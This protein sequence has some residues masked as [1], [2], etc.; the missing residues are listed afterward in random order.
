MRRRFSGLA[1][2]GLLLGMAGAGCGWEDTAGSGGIAGPGERPPARLL[3]QG[4][5]WV[6]GGTAWREVT[7][8]V[9]PDGES[10]GSIP[11]YDLGDVG[12]SV[13][14]EGF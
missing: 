9:P 6:D 11:L 4:F 7:I 3:L 1:L 14:M 5:P 2:G 12:D 10:R 13:R 8:D